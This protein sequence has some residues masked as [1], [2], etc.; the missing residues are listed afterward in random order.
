[1][2]ALA[3][4]NPR[5]LGI[6]TARADRSHVSFALASP[7]ASTSARINRRLLRRL[8]SRASPSGSRATA[9]LSR[10][11]PRTTA[12]GEKQKN[13][14]DASSF[15]LRARRRQSGVV[16]DTARVVA[17][18]R[19]HREIVPPSSRALSTRARRRDAR[20]DAT[21][22]MTN[23]SVVASR[24]NASRDAPLSRHDGARS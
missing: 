23:A 10:F 11:F 22:T 21:R 17:R 6:A 15:V 20:A 24:S 7:P 1:M 13:D 14:T 4:A 19:I 8:T 16:R 9:S 12:L 2:F 18:A 3:T 5:G